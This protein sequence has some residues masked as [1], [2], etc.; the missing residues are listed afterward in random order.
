MIAISWIVKRQFLS[1][2]E[3]ACQVDDAEGERVLRACAAVLSRAG[4]RPVK[5]NERTDYKIQDK[6]SRETRARQS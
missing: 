2:V 1:R 6:A 4:E 5:E 3:V